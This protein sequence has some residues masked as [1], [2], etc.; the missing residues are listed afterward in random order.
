METDDGTSPSIK[1][2]SSRFIWL[3]SK[4]PL[5]ASITSKKIF[6]WDDTDRRIRT[7][8]RV[9]SD[10]RA[11]HGRCLGPSIGPCVCTGCKDCTRL[12]SWLLD[13]RV[14]W[15][16]ICVLLYSSE[17]CASCPSASAGQEPGAYADMRDR[18]IVAIKTPELLTVKLGSDA[19]NPLFDCA[20]LS[21]CSV[22]CS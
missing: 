17:L 4:W 18:A 15:R 12:A 20:H 19:R 5:T 22:G 14:H 7:N 11:P 21:E 6:E 9:Q 16:I 10:E 1:G 2:H 13:W 8:M 3:A